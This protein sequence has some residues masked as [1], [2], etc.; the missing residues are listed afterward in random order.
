[1][2][3]FQAMVEK[4]GDNRLFKR[5]VQATIG[6][7]VLKE[8]VRFPYGPFRF[9]CTLPK[10]TDYTILASSDLSNW[11]PLSSGSASAE[12]VEYVDSDA[13]KHNHRFYR[14]IVGQ[15]S[16]ANILGFA[17]ITLPPGFSLISNPLDAQDNTVAALFTGRPDGTTLNKFDTH[18]FRLAENE[19][20]KGKWSNSSERLMPGEGAIFFNPTTDYKTHSFVGDVLHGQPSIPIPSGFSMRSSILPRPGHIVDD[21]GFPI[22]EGDVIHLFDRDQQKYNLHPYVDGQW[23]AGP[24]IIS[25][26][27]SFWAAKS[28]GANW[29]E[30]FLLQVN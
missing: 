29:A 21:L 24:P 4:I 28:A 11:I 1:M 23:K 6:P 15:L 26:G 7:P 30:K 10:G 19:V 5:R 22:A 16:S 27:E 3:G 13:S 20:V 18:L 12:G 8:G 17:S 25:I 2:M 14:M 9:K